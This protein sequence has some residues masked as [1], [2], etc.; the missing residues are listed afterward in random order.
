[1]VCI[2]HVMCTQQKTDC[3]YEFY[4]CPC[5]IVFARHLQGVYLNWP[6]TI[7]VIMQFLNKELTIRATHRWTL[8]EFFQQ[9]LPCVSFPCSV[10]E[11]EEAA[12]FP[13]NL[14]PPPAGASVS[15][16]A[17]QRLVRRGG[18]ALLVECRAA[19]G[20]SL[21]HRAVITR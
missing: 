1:M 14:S 16:T 19:V 6:L 15:Q 17:L 2:G 18:A 3:M 4:T 11:T 21:S 12:D 10:Q 5:N 9:L 20:E 8:G 13:L 7:N